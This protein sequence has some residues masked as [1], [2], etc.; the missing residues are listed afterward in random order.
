M[1]QEEI[2]SGYNIQSH[3]KNEAFSLEES[4]KLMMLSVVVPLVDSI[5][6]HYMNLLTD[7]I[8]QILIADW[9]I[10]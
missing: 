4:F 3:G 8:V 7:H 1:L 2:T 6:E 10:Q 5:F 9:I